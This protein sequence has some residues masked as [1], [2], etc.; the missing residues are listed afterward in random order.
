MDLSRFMALHKCFLILSYSTRGLF[1]L[2]VGG[3]ARVLRYF[4]ARSTNQNHVHGS[5]FRR[6]PKDGVYDVLC[7][8][9]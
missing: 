2:P 4:R 9:I 7:K 1:D 5:L 3:R 8:T 6:R